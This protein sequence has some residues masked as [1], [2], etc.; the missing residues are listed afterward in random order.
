MRECNSQGCC[1]NQ[2][3]LVASQESQN[4][5]RRLGHPLLTEIGLLIRG[6]GV[7]LSLM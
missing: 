1:K 2:L 5:S 6:S 4:R 7:T 3:V